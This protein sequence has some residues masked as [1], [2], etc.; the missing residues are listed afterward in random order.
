MQTL[1]QGLTSAGRR[2]RNQWGFSTLAMLMLSLGVGATTA[3]FSLIDVYMP[4][5]ARNPSC[6]LAAASSHDPMVVIVDAPPD[7]PDLHDRVSVAYES[8]YEAAGATMESWMIPVAAL[9]DH[10]L[11][12]LLS[13]AALALLVACSNGARTLSARGARL[14]R[15]TAAVPAIVAAVAAL[16]VA[17]LMLRLL[18]TPAF[19]NLLG[20]EPVTRLD[21][22][23]IAFTLCVSALAEARRHSHARGATHPSLARP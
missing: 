1:L 12:A 7:A 16:T 20:F 17:M 5:A 2:V 23:A 18:A 4:H 19:S 15:V 22:R 6:D 14:H 8:R 10:P 9:I 11:L 3:A 21:G 13:A